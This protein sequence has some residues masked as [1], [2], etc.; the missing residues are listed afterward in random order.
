MNLH[1][2]VLPVHRRSLG[3][4]VI[5]A[6]LVLVGVLAVEQCGRSVRTRLD[7]NLRD[8]NLRD[9]P[10]PTSAHRDPLSDCQAC[11]VARVASPGLGLGRR[12]QAA[13]GRERLGGLGVH[14]HWFGRSRQLQRCCWGSGAAGADRVQV[15]QVP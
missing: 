9:W 10:M 12:E 2:E 13:E 7:W 11:G 8:W 5:V 14:I 4:W 3:P 1:R 15:R 6:T